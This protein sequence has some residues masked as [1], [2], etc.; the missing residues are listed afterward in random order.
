[1]KKKWRTG[2]TVGDKCYIIYAN[3]KWMR[4]S[5]TPFGGFIAAVSLYKRG[6]TTRRWPCPQTMIG[7]VL[8]P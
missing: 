8:A 1:M 4:L 2:D 3:E 7:K 5:T 6:A